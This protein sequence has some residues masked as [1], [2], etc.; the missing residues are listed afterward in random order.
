MKAVRSYSDTQTSLGGS[1]QES[2]LILNHYNDIDL[3]F[4]KKESR[5]IAETRSQSEKASD[6]EGSS[7][8]GM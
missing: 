3:D 6:S 2:I 7:S 8:P 5:D 1:G 4:K